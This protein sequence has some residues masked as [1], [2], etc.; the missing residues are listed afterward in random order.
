ML[1]ARLAT[2]FGVDAEFLPTQI[3]YV[4][5]VSGVGEALEEVS[6]QNASVGLRIE[7]GPI[8]SGF[9]YRLAVERGYLLPSFHTAI[10]ETLSAELEAG[11]A[12]LAR[13]RLP[14]DAHPLALLGPDA[15]GRLLPPAHDPRPAQGA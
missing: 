1:A 9:G 15:A 10:E 3:V 7:P 11:P 14:R 4:E 8:G 6:S 2:E 12:G 5:R 13:D